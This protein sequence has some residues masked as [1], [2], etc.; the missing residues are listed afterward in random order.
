MSSTTKPDA[1]IIEI[2]P[3]VRKPPFDRASH[4]R[5]IAHKGGITTRDRYGLDHFH[6]L[7]IAGFDA[8]CRAY[9]SGNRAAAWKAI[10]RKRQ[11][12]RSRTG[13]QPAGTRKLA[14]IARIR[15]QGGGTD[16]AA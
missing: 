10:E 11:R 13:H 1:P 2:D 6:R 5:A 15:Q 9:H 4:C 8:Y 14:E 16:K 3:T 7:G 12:H